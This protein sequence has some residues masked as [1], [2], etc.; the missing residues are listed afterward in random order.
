MKK[1]FIIPIFFLLPFGIFSQSI[2]QTLTKS[3]TEQMKNQV[4]SIFQKM[5]VFAE[6]LDFD[7]L[8]SGVD[9]SHSAG[10]I[11]NGKYYADY[12]SLI[13]EVK[14]SAQGI[15]R[16]DISV[17]KKK[18]T[19]LSDNMMLLTASG[20]S[21]AFLNDGREIAVNFQWSFIYEMVDNHWKVIYSH[22]SITR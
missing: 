5:V 9:D 11:A 21:K 6:K 20:E 17:Q 1:L 12:S 2:G 7:K 18:I 15:N 13:I 22:Q 19:V 8:S 4:D 3:Q 16:Q 10:F 14:L